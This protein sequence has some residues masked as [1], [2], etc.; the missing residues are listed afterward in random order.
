MVNKTETHNWT[1]CR[2]LE[3]LE[4]SALTKWDRCPYQTSPLKAHGKNVSVRGGGWLQ[5]MASSSH[6]TAGTHEPRDSDSTH[7]TA[8]VQSIQNPSVEKGSQTP[9]PSS[10]QEGVRKR[11]A[12]DTCWKWEINSLQWSDTVCQ[13]HTPEQAPGPGVV[14]HGFCVCLFVYLHII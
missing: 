1:I 13:P 2:E 7:T 8:Q 4:Q 10:H 5:E 6:S 14:S 9:S 12:T 3:T 11:F